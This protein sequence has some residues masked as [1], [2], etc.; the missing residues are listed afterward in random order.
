MTS[1]MTSLQSFFLL[2]PEII[3]V[4]AALIAF[5][6]GAFALLL[7]AM[8]KFPLPVALLRQDW[9]ARLHTAEGPLPFGVALGAGAVIVYPQTNIWLSAMGG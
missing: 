7:L 1:H 9:I 5:L 8:R 3:L 6:G 4:A 2:G